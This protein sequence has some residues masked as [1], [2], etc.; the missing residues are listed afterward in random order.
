MTVKIKKHAGA[1]KNNQNAKKLVD[2]D[3]KKDAY[4]Q[5]C[6]WISNGNSKE[7]WRFKHPEMSLTYKTIERYIK[8]SPIDFPPIQKEMAEAESLEHWEKMGLQMMLGEVKGAQPAI[9]QMFMRNKFG[10]DKESKVEHSFEPEARK[11]L[12]KWEE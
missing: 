10:W 12:Q 3:L 9:F 7:A 5:Y 8:E 4:A 11:L 1:P 6:E 2:N